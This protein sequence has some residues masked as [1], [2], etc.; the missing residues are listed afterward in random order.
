M[1]DCAC[2]DEPLPEGNCDFVTCS[3]CKLELECADVKESTLGIKWEKIGEK[4]G[5]VNLVKIS[6]KLPRS[7]AENLSLKSE[8][9]ECK[10]RLDDLDMDHEGSVV[11]RWKYPCIVITCSASEVVSME[12]EGSKV[13]RWKYLCIAITSC[14]S[15]VVT[16]EH[17]GSKVGRWKYPSLYCYHYLCG[18]SYEYGTRG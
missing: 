11:E 14:E 2:C 7:K 18:R 9:D 15:E 3:I 17:E 5:N 16:M 12:H 10:I 8:L 13:G 1:P 6:P 4:I